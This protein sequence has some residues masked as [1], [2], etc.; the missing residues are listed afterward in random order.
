MFSKFPLFLFFLTK[1]SFQNLLPNKPDHLVLLDL[2]K[3]LLGSTNFS[4]DKDVSCLL[5]ILYSIFKVQW[6]E[7]CDYCCAVG[8]MLSITFLFIYLFLQRRHLV[9]EK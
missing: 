7:I 5:C 2:F 4:E 1:S 8:I 9:I 6:Q 3:E